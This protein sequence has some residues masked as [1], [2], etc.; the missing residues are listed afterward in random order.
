MS[1]TS[2]AAELPTV[3]AVADG[4]L[5]L[6]HRL[7]EWVSDAPTMEE[8]V[9]LGNIALDLLGQARGLL[10]SLGD[11]DQLAYFRD[12]DDFHN[13]AICATP[14]GDFAKTMLRQAFAD[15]WLELVWA[16]LADH[17]VD[18]VRGVAA[19]AVKENAYH[20]RHS[21]S[22][23]VRLGDGTEESRRRMLLALEDLWP[24]TAEIAVPGWR[25]AAT[26]VLVEATI[27]V[28]AAALADDAAIAACVEERR[29]LLEEMQS[30]A[31]AH[32]GASW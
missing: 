5:L 14:N 23:V 15:C 19:K 1:P 20:R 27:P 8:D 2:E 31:R 4:C 24:L 21:R 32:P 30:L 17:E 13:P 25:E 18:V 3:E 16:A 9:A 29:A 6:S 12:A 28:P 10:S 22:W 7:T 26:D 11:E